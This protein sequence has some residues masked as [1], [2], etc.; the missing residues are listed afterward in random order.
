MDTK[1][2]RTNALHTTAVTL[3]VLMLA[4]ANF[5]AYAAKQCYTFDKFGDQKEFK[6]GDSKQLKHAKITF[7]PLY[8][9]NL[10]QMPAADSKAIVD[11]FNILGTPPA[12]LLSNKILFR[13]MA[14][15]QLSR[16]TFDYAQNTGVDNNLIDNLAVNG[17]ILSWRG[18][19]L[20]Q[21]GKHA[22]KKDLG[23][24]VKI[25]VT[26][27]PHGDGHW[28]KGKVILESDPMFPTLPNRGIDRFAVGGTTQV[29]IDNLCLEK[30]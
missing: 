23:G 18:T 29:Q 4:F 5:S 20:D 12:L 1:H 2:L 3:T 11:Q 28:V 24:L 30:P 22:G 19:F 6:V 9:E 7:Y 8:D 27:Q 14:D 17:E 21:N 16:V 25:T 13:V 26:E 10:Q 15:Q